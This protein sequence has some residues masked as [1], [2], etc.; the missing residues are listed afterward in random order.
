ML[1]NISV[2]ICSRNPSEALSVRR[3]LLGTAKWPKSLEII[4]MDNREK[5]EGLCAVYNQGVAKAKGRV[6]VFMHEDIWMM[7]KDWDVV[8]LKKFRELPEMQILGVAGSSLLVDYP[9]ALWAV[10]NIPYTFGKVVHLIEEKDEF[11]LTLFNDRDGDQEAVVVDG[12]WFAARKSLFEKISFDEKTF[13][14]FH[15]YDLDISIQALEFG[16]VFIT[17]DIRV[18]HKSEG[19]FK[20][21]WK[22]W[23]NIFIEKW[24]DKLP[25]K[26][27]NEPP[28]S[29]ELLKSANLNLKGKVK[30]PRW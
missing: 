20:E 18:L 27:L 24:K 22:E 28:P 12:L 6:L 5:N 10:A 23:S 8:L 1:P 4:V 26:T 29:K 14:S 9:Y 13:P 15:F 3:N 11:F 30:V 21:E 25:A 17:T 16:K 19:T 2:I 7:E